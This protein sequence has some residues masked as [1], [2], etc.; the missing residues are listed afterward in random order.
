M[1][2][3]NSTERPEASFQSSD[4]AGE[5]LVEVSGV[6]KKFCRSLR[7]AL[8]YGVRDIASEILGRKYEHRLRQDEFW[9]VDNVSFTVKRGEC[10]GI[11]GHNGAGKSTLLK[12]LNGLIKPDKGR[13]AMHGRVSALIEL[14][15]GFNPILTGLENIYNR[16][17]ILGLSKAEVDRK[18]NDIIEFSEIGDFINAPVQS[19]SS[20]MKVRLG[21]AVAAQMEPDVLI[22]DEVLAVGDV[23]FRAKCFNAIQNMMQSTAVIFV[24]HSMPQISRVCSA[25]LVMDRGSS[26]YL[27][28]EV[29]V[30]IEKFYTYFKEEEPC[31]LVKSDKALLRKL[32]IEID[33][34]S[35]EYLD[36]LIINLEVE[37]ARDIPS[38]IVNL[39]IANRELQIV[40]ICSSFVDGF[41]ISN[42]TSPMNLRVNLGRVN[43]SPGRYSLTV[44][45]AERHGG[46]ILAKYHNCG[47]FLV[48]GK[49]YSAVPI[50]ISGSWSLASEY[51]ETEGV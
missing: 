6:S 8:S 45:I 24:T 23:G 11:V 3:I 35:V 49:F 2:S 13:I 19:Y 4:T 14:T 40:A 31:V 17:A 30:G 43:L 22:L 28:K 51:P 1:T 18:L 9:A 25:L 48:K 41:F 10:L 26:V 44:G 37:V 32:E 5:V 27:G 16:A 47:K 33:N 50:Q 36:E 29:S 38:F 39:Q 34:G 20:G 42:H 15:A 46:E 21:F 7:K 12:M